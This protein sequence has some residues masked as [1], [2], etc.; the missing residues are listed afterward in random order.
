MCHYVALYAVVVSLVNLL[1]NIPVLIVTTRSRKLQ[2]DAVTGIIASVALND[3]GAGAVIPGIGAALCV[4]DAPNPLPKPLVYVLGC[5]QSVF[6]Y[7]AMLH[8]ILVA[9]V[10][11]GVIVRPLVYFTVL[12]DGVRRGA[13]VGVWVVG[14]VLGLIPAFAGA[15]FVYERDFCLPSTVS[16][17]VLQTALLNTMLVFTTLVVLALYLKI[18][19]VVKYQLRSIACV[20]AARTAPKCEEVGING[21]AGGGMKVS[22]DISVTT[23]IFGQ[24]VRS[25]KNLF[26]ISGVYLLTYVPSILTVVKV[27]PISADVRTW[28]RLSIKWLYTSASAING[29]LYIALHKSVRA[30]LARILFRRRR[31]TVEEPW[32]TTV[33]RKTVY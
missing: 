3:I 2:T 9:V 27:I 16:Q 15:E 10:K 31:I 8:F 22:K 23:G 1:V 7:C 26:I 33:T 28:L 5:A 13:V 6:G 20:S 14:T 17:S 4:A 19:L 21:G 25:A 30:E 32:S 24:S 18:F 12:T 29:I 11:C